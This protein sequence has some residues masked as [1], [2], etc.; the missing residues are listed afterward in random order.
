MKTSGHFRHNSELFFQPVPGI[1]L[2]KRKL[3]ILWMI[4]FGF[5]VC[6]KYVE[7]KKFWSGVIIYKGRYQS[8]P[9]GRKPH[10]CLPNGGLG[11]DRRG[12]SRVAGGGGT[13]LRPGRSKLNKFEHVLGRVHVWWCSMQHIN[14]MQPLSALGTDRRTDKHDWSYYFSATSLVGGYK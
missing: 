11:P 13:S 3:R 4:C 5:I 2:S 1:P 9:V 14:S 12:G 10:N 8:I 6:R 7:I